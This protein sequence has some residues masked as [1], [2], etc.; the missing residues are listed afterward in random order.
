MKTNPDL[1]LVVRSGAYSL[2]A[3][4]HEAEIWLQDR[5]P[6]DD[7]EQAFPIQSQ[8]YEA[9]R[10]D[11]LAYLADAFI[12]GLTVAVEGDD[13]FA[14]ALADAEIVDT[15]GYGVYC[16]V[17]D[18]DSPKYSASAKDAS[19]ARYLLVEAIDDSLQVLEAPPAYAGR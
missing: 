17:G 3:N 16:L 6:R 19:G 15:Y 9:D 11:I 7:Y 10:Q 5:L 12:D 14:Q 4:T 2:E 8:P 18:G 13:S 1:T